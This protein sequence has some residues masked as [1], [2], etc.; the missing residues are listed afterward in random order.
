MNLIVASLIVLL[1]LT[2]AGVSKAIMDKVA[3]HFYRS[4]FSSSGHDHFWWSKSLS[5][6]NKYKNRI[7]EDG[8]KFWG[9]V[10]IFVFTTDAWH[11]F[12]MIYGIT[13]TIAFALIGII[14]SDSPIL[15]VTI[16]M[17]SQ[18][19]YRAVFAHFHGVV[20]EKK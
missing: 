20:L 14:L 7:K 18:V 13:V 1:L 17:L 10:T 2:T 3:H 9:S 6:N 11:L 19:Y 8:P 16:F 15:L 5:S 12:Q 4:V